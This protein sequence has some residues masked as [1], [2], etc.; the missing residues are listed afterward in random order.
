MK[1]LNVFL[2]CLVLMSLS[3]MVLA[4][5]EE[6]SLSSSSSSSTSTSSSQY[7]STSKASSST[8]SSSSQYASSTS[9][10]SSSSIESSSSQESSSSESSIFATTT[11]VDC[12]DEY[13]LTCMELDG[14]ETG[15]ED[16]YTIFYRDEAVFMNCEYAEE[17]CDPSG[18]YEECTVGSIPSCQEN[19]ADSCDILFTEEECESSY[20]DSDGYYYDC[21]WIYGTCYMGY[22]ECEVTLPECQSEY[23][24]GCPLIND[25]EDCSNAYYEGEGGTYNC[26]WI[27]GEGEYCWFGGAC[28]KLVYEQCNSNDVVDCYELLNETACNA[29]YIEGRDDYGWNCLWWEGEWSGCYYAESCHEGSPVTTTLPPMEE[30]GNTIEGSVDMFAAIVTVIIAIVPILIIIAVVA[31]LV[32]SIETVGRK[33][34]GKL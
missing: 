7:S 30:I 26:E 33:V 16:A 17:L 32:G 9:V 19:V 3:G 31:F 15:C 27:I 2:V 20:V 6:S 4:T 8:S 10:E 22:Q 24:F 25:S 11:L 5:D 29:A 21:G 12:A 34:D 1:L 13:V 18:E 28:E 23:S 14:N